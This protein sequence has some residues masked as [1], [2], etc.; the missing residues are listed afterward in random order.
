[1]MF[2]YIIDDLCIETATPT[3]EKGLA[4]IDDDIIFHKEKIL[5]KK[6]YNVFKNDCDG[7]E[8][9]HGI[10]KSIQSALKKII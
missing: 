5:K 4:F 8:I 6:L 10:S 2:E 1:M 9:H 7:F 3:Q